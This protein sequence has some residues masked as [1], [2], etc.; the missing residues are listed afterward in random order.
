[1]KDKE[2]GIIAVG[3]NWN[4]EESVKLEKE[5]LSFFGFKTPTQLYKFLKR[6]D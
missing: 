3:H 5:V 6:Y 4:G 1:L 2:V